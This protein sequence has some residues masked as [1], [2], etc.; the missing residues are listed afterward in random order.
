MTTS[1][2]RCRYTRHL[3]AELVDWDR[4]E[5]LLID[6]GLCDLARRKGRK[7]QTR[8]NVLYIGQKRARSWLQ[9]NGDEC[10][11]VTVVDVA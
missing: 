1:V 9:A 3:I 2:L 8:V 7:G 4:K 6:D 5:G 11:G 10:V